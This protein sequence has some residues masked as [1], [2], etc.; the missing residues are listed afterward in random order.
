MTISRNVLAAM[1]AVAVGLGI[2]A[3]A[4]AA[5]LFPDLTTGGTAFA[6]G[7]TLFG[8]G[9]AANAFD[10]SA[11]TKVGMNVTGG[12]VTAAAPAVVGYTFGGGSTAIVRSYSL[13]SANDG[14]NRDPR[15][16]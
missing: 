5:V 1:A 14:P 2:N 4:S 16:F 8:D 13:T 3:G 15:D 12:N 10:D 11:A 9:P 6:T 7:G